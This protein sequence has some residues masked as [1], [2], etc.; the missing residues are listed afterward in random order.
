[1]YRY[2]CIPMPA[3]RCRAIDTRM[4]VNPHV[5]A[6]TT[7]W[8]Q[9]DADAAADVRVYVHHGIHTRLDARA[10]I[11]THTYRWAYHTPVRAHAHAH[12]H[13]HADMDSIYALIHI[14]MCSHIHIYMYTSCRRARP[15]RSR[16]AL[17]RTYA[18]AHTRRHVLYICSQTYTY[19]L[20]HT[21]VYMSKVTHN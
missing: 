8:L 17:P 10:S 19:E 11:Q 7:R 4:H 12:A 20:R 15:R 16:R 14:H 9:T 6:C 18:H 1:M 5:R 21:P 2:A 3:R 13:V